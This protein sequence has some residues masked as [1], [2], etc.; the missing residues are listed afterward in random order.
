MTPMKLSSEFGCDWPVVENSRGVFQNTLYNKSDA[1]Q[2][3]EKGPDNLFRS[4]H[5]LPDKADAPGDF[6]ASVVGAC[7]H[8]SGV[9]NFRLLFSHVAVNF[10]DA[11]FEN[12][13]RA[14]DGA[15]LTAEARFPFSFPEPQAFL[16]LSS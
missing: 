4:P 16:L 11:N 7:V 13:A 12:E 1:L 6:D 5:K 10:E 8:D 15:R 3:D 14:Q 9:E 2:W